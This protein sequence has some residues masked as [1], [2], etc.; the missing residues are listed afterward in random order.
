MPVPPASDSSAWSTSTIS[1]ISDADESRRGSAVSRPGRVGE[2]HEQ[3]GGEQVG[4]ERGQAVV[5]AEADLVVGD[6][7]VL[8]DDRHHAELEQ[9]AE[10]APG[11]GGTA[12]GS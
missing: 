4:D 3:V 6:G 1:S 2:Q 10:R 11:R 5:V 12:G 7:V 9:P 8:V